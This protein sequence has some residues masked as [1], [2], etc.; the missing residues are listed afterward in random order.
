MIKQYRKKPVVI[1]AM[2]WTGNN[3]IE[4]AEFMFGAN[5]YINN[6]KGY[7]EIW[8]QPQ[9]GSTYSIGADV[10]E[11]L[12]NGD[13]SCAYVGNSDFD[14][15]AIIFEQILVLRGWFHKKLPPVFIK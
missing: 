1:E 13:F 4:V 7:V 5:V 8:Q 12:V 9:L 10:A 11:G 3:H 14:I 15:V 6:P 2:Q